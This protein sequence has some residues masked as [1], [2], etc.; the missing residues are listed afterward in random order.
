LPEP[1]SNPNRPNRG[2]EPLVIHRPSVTRKPSRA[3]ICRTARL[4]GPI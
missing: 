1:A 4:V 2:A 3:L